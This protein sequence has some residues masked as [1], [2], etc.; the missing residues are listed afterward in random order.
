MNAK[1]N[2][3]TKHP[4]NSPFKLTVS[5]LRDWSNF[6]NEVKNELRAASP[7]G[8]PLQAY[9]KMNQIMYHNTGNEA[10]VQAAFVTFVSHT[11]NEVFTKAGLGMRMGD[12]E[13]GRSS[14]KGAKIE[15]RKPDL[16]MW[17]TKSRKTLVVGEIKTPWTTEKLEGKDGRKYLAA[18]LGIAIQL[19]A[20]NPCS[21]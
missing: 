1:K 3:R 21:S 8:E 19:F 7:L 4:S 10:G 18:K 17:E 9:K 15:G 13:T 6:P 12:F 14:I 20:L 16:I 2:F 11:I 5:Q